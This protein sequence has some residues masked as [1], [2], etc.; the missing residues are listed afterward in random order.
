MVTLERRLSELELA[1]ASHAG[2]A[3][4]PSVPVAM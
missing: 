3:E 1:R 2:P 4:N